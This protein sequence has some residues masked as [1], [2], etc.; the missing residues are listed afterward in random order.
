MVTIKINQKNPYIGN[1]PVQR[2]EVEES[3]W[4][5]WVKLS[6]LT[7][8]CCACDNFV[9]CIRAAAREDSG[10]RRL[11]RLHVRP[12]KTQISLRI[13]AVWSE[14]SLS[15]WGRFG[16]LSTHNVSCED[17][18]QILVVVVSLEI[19]LVMIWCFTSIS[20][21]IKSYRD[22][23]STIKKEWSAIQ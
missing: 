15:A 13:R 9:F 21:L 19:L 18:D 2:V 14:S 23:E 17:F 22:D 8:F 4:Y 10:L 16:S 11:T 5:K 3:T 1:W 7:F 12:A 6:F 20:T